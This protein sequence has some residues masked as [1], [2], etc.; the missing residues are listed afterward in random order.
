MNEELRAHSL[1]GTWAVDR[2][3]TGRRLIG[4]RWVYTVKDRADGSVPLYK[5]RLVAQG[6][7]TIAG[8]DYTETFSPVIRF[9]S[10]R[11][12]FALAAQFHLQIEQLD[13]RTAF[14][15]GTLPTPVY[16]SPPPGV[17]LG[18]PDAV[19]RLI[20]S[21]YGLPNSPLCFYLKIHSVLVEFG[22]TRSTYEYGLYFKVSSTGILLV[23]LY[24]DDL[25]LVS[26]DPALVA[27]VKAKLTSVFEMKDLGKVSNFLGMSVSQTP[28]RVSLDL[29]VYLTRLLQ[30]FGMSHCNPVATPLP[31]SID[32][33]SDTSPL[34]SDS[35]VYRSMVGKLIFACNTVRPD[36]AFSVSTLSRY[37]SSPREG[38]LTAA[39]H[40]L[41]YVKGTL[42][43]KLVYRHSSSFKI[44]GYCDADWAG[45]KS[46][47]KS[48]SGYFFSISGAPVI[49][50]SKKQHSIALSSTESEYISLSASVK[51]L[52]WLTQ[53]LKTIHLQ[54]QQITEIFEDNEGCIALANHPA[55]HERTKHIDIRYHFL[56]FYVKSVFV[57]CPIATVDNPADTLTKPLAREKFVKFRELLGLTI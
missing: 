15:N 42:H 33:A 5:A 52:L 45:D 14:L 25:A 34:L 57:I 56:R 43:L 41:R 29:E 50:K 17:N 8:I 35:S 24:V 3:P 54:P 48:T 49:W 1:H 40:V 22:L 39:K 13:V 23:S 7:R 20:R 4:C 16:M 36:L 38:H 11:V 6:F 26:N 32:L 12:L 27:A 46:D 47:R 21:I 30:D 51:D 19:C 37:L 2:L 9:E 31:P 53:L 18:S 55:H 44:T 10:L 28:G